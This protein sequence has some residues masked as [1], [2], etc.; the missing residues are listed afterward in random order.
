MTEPVWRNSLESLRWLLLQGMGRGPEDAEQM[1]RTERLAE[2]A[3]LLKEY[4]WRSM[5]DRLLNI[6]LGER[7]DE[8]GGMSWDSRL[9]P[10][11]PPDI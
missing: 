3:A 8:G 4:S 1:Q 5:E 10:E 9:F 2:V 6:L 7:V 11:Q